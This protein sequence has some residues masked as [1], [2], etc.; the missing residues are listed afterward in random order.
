MLCSCRSFRAGG[1]AGCTLWR[2]RTPRPWPSFHADPDRHHPPTSRP[3]PRGVGTKWP[4]GP[5][6]PRGLR[7]SPSAPTVSPPPRLTLLV[8]LLG[9]HGHRHGG[10]G[11]GLAA[12]GQPADLERPE[13]ALQRVFGGGRVLLLGVSL[14]VCGLCCRPVIHLQPHELGAN[15]LAVKDEGGSPLRPQ[16]GRQHPGPAWAN[17]CPL[18]PV[19]PDL[20]DHLCVEGPGHPPLIGTGPRGPCGGPPQPCGGPLGGS[21]RGS[22]DGTQEGLPTTTPTVSQASYS[23][24]SFRNSLWP[25]HPVLIVCSSGPRS[26]GGQVGRHQARPEE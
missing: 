14:P 2:P 13:G 23:Q 12:A 22:P 4:P 9:D 6:H 19:L 5:Q 11:R 24:P 18:M 26:A 20:G 1:S 21:A 15:A 8:L 25:E 7:S 17:G 3:L 16:Q 10:R